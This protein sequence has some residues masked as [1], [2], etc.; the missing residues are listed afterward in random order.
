MPQVTIYLDAES[1]RLIEKAAKREAVSLSRWA[2]EK[3]VLAAGSPSWPEGYAG[4]LG[5]I[6]DASFMAPEEL[7]QNSDQSVDLDR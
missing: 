6:A 7:D 1:S 2:R 4:V 3:L 5:S